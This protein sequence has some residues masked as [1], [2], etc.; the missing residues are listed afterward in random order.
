MLAGTSHFTSNCCGCLVFH[1]PT[2]LH[3]STHIYTDLPSRTQIHPD[4][5]VLPE[6][7]SCPDLT[8]PTKMP[9]PIPINRSTKICPEPTHFRTASQTP[10]F[11]HTYRSTHASHK[12]KRKTYHGVATAGESG[13]APMRDFS[14]SSGAHTHAAGLCADNATRATPAAAYGLL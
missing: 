4:S 9:G 8:R 12:K 5:Q 1:C 3:R 10:I 11:S 6:L 13:S 14:K 2:D 7:Q